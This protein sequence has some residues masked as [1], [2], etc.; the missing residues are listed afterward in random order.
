MKTTLS[1]EHRKTLE[2]FVA[3]SRVAAESGAENALK[4][5]I[6]VQ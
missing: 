2:T 3:Q 6:S 1:R 5:S 4:V